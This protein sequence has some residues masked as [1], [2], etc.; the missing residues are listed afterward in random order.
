MLKS[1]VFFGAFCAVV[2]TTQAQSPGDLVDRAAAEHARMRTARVQF[3]QVITNPL[4]GNRINARGQVLRKAPGLLAITFTDPAGD[5][6]IADGRAVWVYLPSTSPGQVLKM[7]PGGNDA[8]RLD[9]ASQ[10]LRS[11]R[12]RFNIADAGTATVGGRPTRVVL[13][14]PKGRESFMRAKV[15]IDTQNSLV[16]RFE[17][18]EPSGLVRDVTLTSIQANVAVPA[19]AFRFTVPPGVR[20]IDQGQLGRM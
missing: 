19:S 6:I 16:R 5:R 20:V 8:E 2:G 17:V 7:N 11:P 1:I 10:L 12:T 18:T 3:T 15:W 14:T 9:P 4:T 13:L